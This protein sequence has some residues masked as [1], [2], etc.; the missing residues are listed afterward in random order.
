MSDDVRVVVES[1]RPYWEDI[2]RVCRARFVT[3]AKDPSE[4]GPIWWN[5]GR[6][7]VGGHF[8]VPAF[9]VWAG[10]GADEYKLIQKAMRAPLTNPTLP[11]GLVDRVMVAAGMEYLV[12]SL[13]IKTTA[14]IRAD[15][16]AARKRARGP[17]PDLVAEY[18]ARRGDGRGRSP[19]SLQALKAS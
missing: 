5:G 13:Y 8:D 18:R 17:G 19:G 3:K 6:G 1:F 10:I 2:L 9:L 16:D 12:T 4:D 11:F 15:A 14:Q 7:A